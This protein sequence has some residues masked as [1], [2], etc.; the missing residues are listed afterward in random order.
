MDAVFF[1]QEEIFSTV[2]LM[3]EDDRADVTAVVQTHL[4]VLMAIR[5]RARAKR[6]A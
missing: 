4:H 2:A 3:A 1:E 6:I 5:R